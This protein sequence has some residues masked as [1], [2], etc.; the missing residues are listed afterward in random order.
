M[1]DATERKDWLRVGTACR[2]EIGGGTARWDEKEGAVGEVGEIKRYESSEKSG[3]R[4]IEDWRA[5]SGERRD[6]AE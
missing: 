1:S 3:G 6:G 5:A 4:I 2:A